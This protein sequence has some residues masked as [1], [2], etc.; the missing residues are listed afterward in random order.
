MQLYAETGERG[1]LTIAQRIY[2][3]GI[4]FGQRENGGFG[5]DNC[6]GAVGVENNR[7]LRLH[8]PEAYWCC[9]MRGGE[10]IAS[11]AEYAY[12]VD[13]NT[14][15]VPYFSSSD[16]EIPVG[17]GVL[18]LSQKSSYPMEGKTVFTVKNNTA[19]D[20]VLSC[21]LPD[22]A[23]QLAVA[24]AEYSVDGG[25]LSLHVTA[26]TTEISI[27]FVLPYHAETPVGEHNEK[28]GFYAIFRGNAMYSVT[29]DE[30]LSVSHDALIAGADGLTLRPLFDAYETDH[31]PRQVLFS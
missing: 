26:D 16:A 3:N 14:V 17:G 21:Y 11:V 2:Y 29:T 28:D 13:G 8:C 7:I 6:L 24:G 25:M 18:S 23:E 30:A 5:C 22:T 4:G 15:T 20:V 19:G 9:T 1:Y 27:D 31:A 12:L 10:G